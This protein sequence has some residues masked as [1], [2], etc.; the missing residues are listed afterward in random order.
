MSVGEGWGQGQYQH[1]QY[2][3]EYRMVITKLVILIV[4]II[5]KNGLWGFSK[6]IGAHTK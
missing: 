1:Y 4:K 6:K 5:C 2:I 3:S